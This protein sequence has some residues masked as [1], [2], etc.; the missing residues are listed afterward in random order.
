M[1]LL[2]IS[3]ICPFVFTSTTSPVSAAITS[4]LDSC[5]PSCLFSQLPVASLKSLLHNNQSDIFSRC[6][7][8]HVSPTLKLF[9]TETKL[10]SVATGSAFLSDYLTPPSFCSLSS[11]LMRIPLGLCDCPAPST[12][13]PGL[14][15][16][17]FLAVGAASLLLCVVNVFSSFGSHI[18]HLLP[19]EGM[20]TP[21]VRS[22]LSL[23]QV[24]LTPS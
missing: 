13:P 6:R 24:L 19:K 20:Q 15:H 16:M 3:L 5:K 9:L 4:C 12:L 21:L 17:L 1:D 2:N 23:S 8:V 11:T 7:R 18:K 14:L 10:L 22:Y